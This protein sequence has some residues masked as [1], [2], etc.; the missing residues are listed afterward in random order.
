MRI[1]HEN[2][3]PLLDRQRLLA[4]HREICA[5]RGNG[6]TKKHATVQ[7][8]LDGSLLT[9]YFFHLVVMKEMV[10]RGYNVD[11]KWVDPCYRGKICPAADKE[12][13]MNKYVFNLPNTY[14]EH[15][16]EYFKEC[17]ENLRNKGFI[18]K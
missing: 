12:M 4:Q 18:I 1:W 9:L 6:W 17:I 5:M 2:L 7:Y 13:L 14:P 16:D 15:N 11:N 3:I 10:N 8:A